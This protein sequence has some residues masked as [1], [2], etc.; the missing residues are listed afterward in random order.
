MQ[1]SLGISDV[2]VAKIEQKIFAERASGQ[3]EIS[4]YNSSVKSYIE[5]VEPQNLGIKTIKIFL[6]S[7][8][9]LKDDRAAFERLIGRENR[10]YIKS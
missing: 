3:Q 10:E 6:A 1:A 2:E 9:E 4:A 5:I 8:S 7:S